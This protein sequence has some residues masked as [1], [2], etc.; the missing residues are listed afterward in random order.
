MSQDPQKK[1]QF[2]AKS[3]FLT[4]AQCPLEREVVLEALQ[5]LK[6]TDSTN[7]LLKAC[8]GREAHQDGNFHLHVCAWYTHN[9]KFYDCRYFDIE[10]YH[11]NIKDQ[12]VKRKAKA[13]AYCS[14][15]DPEPLQFN[16]DIKEETRAR[17]CHKKILTKRILDDKEPLHKLVEDGEINLMD[18]PKWKAGLEVYK[19][20]KKD[21]KPDLPNSIPNPWEK[22]MPVIDDKKK[23]YWVWSKTPDVGKT[24]K[25]L[26]PLED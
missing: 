9:L 1:F 11:P 20:L 16:M 10:G 25:F 13:L 15:E 12:G 5:R 14:K 6:G 17:E 22:D 24:R 21:E 2:C 7:Q 26:N 18:L 23:H 3:I 19:R 4:Y 8:I